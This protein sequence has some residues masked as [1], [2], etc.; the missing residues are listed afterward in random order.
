VTPPTSP[1]PRIFCRSAAIPDCAATSITKG[2]KGAVSAEQRVYSDWYPLRLIRV[3]GA[4]FYDVGRAWGEPYQN[5]PD[6]HWS[7]NIGFGLRLLSARSATGT[8]L[9]L[10]IAF[11]LRREPGMDSYQLVM[12]SKSGF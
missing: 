12:V 10:D 4:V 8:T 6:A 5:F 9:H 3:G 1:T 11:P 2:S 7:A